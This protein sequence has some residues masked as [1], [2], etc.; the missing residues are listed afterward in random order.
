MEALQFEI[1]QSLGD[2][3]TLIAKTYIEISE[4]FVPAKFSQS[5]DI[6][7]II[8]TLAVSKQEMYLGNLNLDEQEENHFLP[9]I[10]NSSHINIKN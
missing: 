3:D 1:R 4:V 6:L 8:I 10:F 7:V 9:L 5:T 2:A